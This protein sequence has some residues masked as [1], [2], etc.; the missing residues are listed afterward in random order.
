MDGTATENEFKAVIRLRMKRARAGK[1]LS[2]QKMAALLGVEWEAYKKWENR[3]SSIIPAHQMLRFCA[4]TDITLNDLLSFPA[5]HELAE[6]R[7]PER[8]R[9]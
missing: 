3:G 2:Q 1:G 4:F 7:L 8:R 5:K 9:A 6:V